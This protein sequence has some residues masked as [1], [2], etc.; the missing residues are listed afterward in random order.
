[1]NPGSFA[2]RLY[3]PG[4]PPGWG[5]IEDAEGRVAGWTYN[6]PNL[7][8]GDLLVRELRQSGQ[9]RRS[10]YLEVVGTGRRFR[11]GYRDFARRVRRWG[12]A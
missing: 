11:M 1:M 12:D 10:V 3:D 6:G 2:A 9:Q 5:W 8:L 4:Q 7:L